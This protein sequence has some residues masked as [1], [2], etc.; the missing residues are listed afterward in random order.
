MSVARRTD[1]ILRQQIALGMQPWGG[2][3]RRRSPKKK[4]GG[5]K[6]SKGIRHCVKE[7]RH[8]SGRMR[9]SEYAMGGCEGYGVLIGGRRRRVG[10]PKGSGSKGIRHC[11]RET[12]HPSGRMR[13]AQYAPGGGYRRKRAGVRAG[14]RAGS[15]GRSP[16]ISFVHDWANAHGMSYSMAL[17]DHGSQISSAYHRM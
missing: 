10:R 12:R 1:D 11:V 8:P 4:M 5:S 13:C 17:R 3:R 15:K 2:A 6:R 16:W 9:C 7:S 14:V